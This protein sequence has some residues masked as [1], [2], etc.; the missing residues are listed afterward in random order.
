MG[1]YLQNFIYLVNNQHFSDGLRITFSILIP[2][3]F[4]SQIENIQIAFPFCLGTLSTSIT[5]NPGAWEERK[6]GMLQ[7]CISI[8]IT[9]I[10]TMFAESSLVWMGLEV[11]FFCF[12]CSMLPVY[13]LRTSLIGTATLLVMVLLMNK[14]LPPD[15]IIRTGLLVLGGG[16]WYFTISLSFFFLR[17]L[18]HAKKALGECMIGIGRYLNIKSAL[19]QKEPS[20]KGIFIKVLDQQIKINELQELCRE[21]ILRSKYI[22]DNPKPQAQKII[23]GFI[24]VQDIYEN[25]L[26]THFNYEVIRTKNN[27]TNTLSEISDCLTQIGN[28]LKL[29][30]QYLE[31]GQSKNKLTNDITKKINQRIDL[32]LE[33]KKLDPEVKEVA[34]KIHDL[35]HHLSQLKQIILSPSYNP[36]SVDFRKFKL[37][38]PTF[39]IQPFIDNLS[40]N[41]SVFRHA[42]RVTLVAIIGLLIGKLI[43]KEGH[44]YWI[45]LTSIFILKPSY[46]LSKKRNFERISGTIVGAVMGY[47]LL[48][49]IKDKTFLFFIMTIFMVAAYTVQR[50]NYILLI[51]FIT[52]YIFIIFNF[53]GVKVIQIL[54]ERVV[55]TLIGCSLAFIGAY[56]ILPHWESDKIKDLMKQLVEANIKYL[57]NAIEFLKSSRKDETE[58]RLARK[59]VF[60]STA[61]IQGAYQRMKSEPSKVRFNLQVLNEFILLNHSLSSFIAGLNTSKS[62]ARSVPINQ[63]YHAV[64]TLQDGIKSI[65][66]SNLIPD[67]KMNEEQIPDLP[68]GVSTLDETANKINEIIKKL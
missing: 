27:D 19:Y 47:G 23:I 14:P 44:S 32:L 63:L 20:I 38:S 36:L 42:I 18:G 25:I 59:E 3:L 40:K 16:L 52:P 54:E 28:E 24:K 46:S 26:G 12:I 53:L 50:T 66:N 37:E 29:L 8:F 55:D 1:K 57:Q 34:A 65:D 56:L 6:N 64:Q 21:Q 17:P 49:F 13:N 48:Y 30:G 62:P 7:T 45:L 60:I 68:N 67:N 61:N 9:A 41:S 11:I 4:L 10:I 15:K 43:L 2:A 31:T 5:D 51:L 58:Y 39:T 22:I 35:T 33:N